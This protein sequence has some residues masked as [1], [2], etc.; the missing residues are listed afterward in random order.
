M[1]TLPDGIKTAAAHHTY[2]L[3]LLAEQLAPLGYRHR[4]KDMLF[5]G[6]FD[7]QMREISYY[8]HCLHGGDI[9]FSMQFRVGAEVP[10]LAGLYRHI[11]GAAPLG[12]LLA[13]DLGLFGPKVQAGMTCRFHEITRLEHTLQ[14]MMQRVAAFHD[15]CAHSGDWDS[16]TAQAPLL[17]R[18][19]RALP[20][21]SRGYG[22]IISFSLLPVLYC[23]Y[24]RPAWAAEILLPRHEADRRY[25]AKANEHAPLQPLLAYLAAEYDFRLPETE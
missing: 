3:A 25:G 2:I 9:S 4:V 6:D 20:E 13:C 23:R 22:N 1:D 18:K 12:P 5:R 16:L 7:G 17:Y 8:S 21:N 24:G 11:Y 10:L 14:D 19:Q 15:F